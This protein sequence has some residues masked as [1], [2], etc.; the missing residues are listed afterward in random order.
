MPAAVTPSGVR[1]GDP[2]AL[3][4]LCAV[5][6]PSVLAY[7]RHVAG[8]AAAGDAA[9]DAFASFRMS[10][11][12]TKALAEL[13]PE[14]LLISATR[15]AAASRADRAPLG[16][17]AVVPLLL[18]ARADT[19][20]S[21][22]DLELLQEHLESCSGCHAPVARFEA[23]ERA[24][25][26]P[27][28]RLMDP[29]IIAAIIAA[30][31]AAVP[32][33]SAAAP[34]P[35]TNGSVPAPAA[36]EA[37]PAMEPAADA[38]REP[39]TAEFQTPDG[40][41]ADLAG[42]QASASDGAP[43]PD[44]ELLPEAVEPP[45]RARRRSPKRAPIGAHIPRVRRSPGTRK[46]KAAPPTAIARSAGRRARPR[47]RSGRPLPIVLPVAVVLVA[48]LGALFVA[49]VF[50]GDDPASSPRVA[51][52]AGS[53]AQSA[54]AD[55]VVVPGAKQAGDVESAK[56][57][58]RARARRKREAAAARAESA[59]RTAAAPPAA[60]AAPAPVVTPPPPPPPPAAPAAERDGSRKV[61]AGSGATGAEQIPPAEDT[62]TV[63][64][65]APAPEPA[66][67]P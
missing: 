45:S 51:V 58:E 37:V 28:D 31:A 59:R 22:A 41:E 12:Q 54:P 60:A 40:L 56:A 26:E 39:A 21:L 11:V 65:L 4:G 44:R 36:T 66:A 2:A 15:R 33:G 49:G 48:V 46:A 9:A 38:A 17:C 55:V 57:R 64:D 20:I 14:A 30:M 32:A 47:S 5:R 18:A 67:A 10:V 50:G 6:G 8:E 25:C 24:Y 7:C 3:A 35:V 34:A 19:T 62:S 63:P 23:A 29:A 13:D 53:P 61:D 16:I 52:P 27:P 43:E 1:D 42:A